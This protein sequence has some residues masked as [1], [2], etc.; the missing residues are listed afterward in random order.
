MKG[1]ARLFK[2]KKDKVGIKSSVKNNTIE[3]STSYKSTRAK[4]DT[5]L[6][7]LYALGG[8]VESPGGRATTMLRE[9]IP[10]DYRM[11][12]MNTFT[13]ALSNMEREGWIK[14]EINGKTTRSIELVQ[15]PSD[16]EP[17]PVVWQE[18]AVEV[19]P[20]GE[21]SQVVENKK[22]E[23]S[24]PE[25]ESPTL[26]DEAKDGG[27]RPGRLAAR[28]EKME[29]AISAQVE[30]AVTMGMMGFF[31]QLAVAMG[32]QLP[33]E[34]SDEV[35]DLVERLRITQVEINTMG[36]ELRYERASSSASREEMNRVLRNNY[37]TKDTSPV[38][39]S[40]LPEAWRSLGNHA[41]ANGWTL[42]RTGG[43]HTMW[44]HPIEGRY[45]SSST[46]SDYR[47][48]RNARSDME[49]M[50]LPKE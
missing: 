24:S 4:Y 31:S 6:N 8:K 1:R 7:T 34:Q 43:G 45:F 41:I 9:K 23:D 21:T 15:Q 32:Y 35:G 3:G 30:D 40:E 36:D 27:I 28:L 48:V 12:N 44:K 26:E 29:T 37:A 39:A 50:G 10:S 14:R 16:W 38:R 18:A 11:K 17:T 33:Q 2:R 13:T 5:I 42:H 19:S 47:S 49:K 22:P 46:S 20:N 25:M